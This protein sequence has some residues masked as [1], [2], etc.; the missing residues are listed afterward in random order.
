MSGEHTIENTNPG[1][2]PRD[3]GIVMSGLKVEN[4]EITCYKGMILVANSLGLPD[5][6][7]LFQQNLDEEIEAS[8]QLNEIGQTAVA[9]N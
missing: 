2:Q 8:E 4:F 6:V 1:T 3:I 9:N 7:D 5:L